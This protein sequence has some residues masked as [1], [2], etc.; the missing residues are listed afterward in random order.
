MLRDKDILQLGEPT[1]GLDSD[2][3]DCIIEC[4]RT[5]SRIKLVVLITHDEAV[6]K[7]SEVLRN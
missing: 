2:N 3:A 4:L 7:V 5:Y 1:A 6:V